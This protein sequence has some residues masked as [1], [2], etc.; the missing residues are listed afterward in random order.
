MLVAGRIETTGTHTKFCNKIALRRG[1]LDT[2]SGFDT[3]RYS[4]LDL[5]DHRYI[6]SLT[7]FSLPIEVFLVAFLLS[8]TNFAALTIAS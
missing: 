6:Y 1:G 2:V 5:L 4:T 7:T 3:L 8:N